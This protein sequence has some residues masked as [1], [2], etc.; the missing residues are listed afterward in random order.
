MNKLKAKLLEQL[1]QGASP[2]ALTLTL[3]LGLALGTIPLL[4]STTLLCAGVAAALRL[5]QPLMQLI[6]Y[7]VYPLQLALYVPLIMMGARLL[8]P[9][10][11]TLTLEGIFAMFR[12][13]LGGAIAKL[14]WA[15]LGAV[16]IWGAVA[17]PLG[18]LLYAGLVRVV[19]NFNKAETTTV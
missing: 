11:G 8:D 2:E 4:G 3:V 14:F 9:G 15:N 5:N 6:N 7:F 19:R 1:K 18:M 13:N 10:L 17:V 12:A 16:L